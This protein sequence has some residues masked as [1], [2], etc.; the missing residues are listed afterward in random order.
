MRIL[1]IVNQKGGCGKT[2]IAVNL[3]A[4]ISATGKKILLVDMD[5]QGHASMALG[6]NGDAP[7]VTM[8]NALTDDPKDM[9]PFSKTLI[10]ADDNLW[11]APSNILLCA[12]E[13]QL[14]GKKGR[15]DRFRN[16][17]AETI[18]AYD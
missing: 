6:I 5:P 17:L 13:Q 7:G 8:Y 14:A 15:E 10:Q 11:V 1:A 2:T 16:C 4:C 18:S 3:A 9:A 12:I